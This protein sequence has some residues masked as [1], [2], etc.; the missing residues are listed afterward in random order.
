MKK[1]SLCVMVFFFFVS[2]VFAET[3]KIGKEDVQKIMASSVTQGNNAVNIFDGDLNTRWESGWQVDPSWISIE[4]KNKKL[5]EAISIKWENAAGNAYKIQSSK[6]GK[7]WETVAAVEDGKSG[8]MRTIKLNAATLTKF[9]RILGE[10][11]TDSEHGYSI[12]EVELNPV[13]VSDN[14]KV[15]IVNAEAS[16]AQKE[17]GQDYSAKKAVDGDMGSRWSSEFSDPQWLKVE[18]KEATSIRSVKIKWEAA[19]AKNYKIQVSD[20]GQTWKEVASVSDGLANEERAITFKSVKAKFVRVYGEV[21]NGEW[22]YSIF[23]IGVYK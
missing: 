4:L 5:V 21:R 8:E 22:G 9:I 7:K 13:V 19:S 15:A 18:L 16:S 17:D 12:Y 23:E 14:D 20:D 11:R 6:N 2:A 3:V 1:V 10:K